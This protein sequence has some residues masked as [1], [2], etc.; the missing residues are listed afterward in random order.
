MQSWWLVHLWVGSQAFQVVLGVWSYSRERRVIESQFGSLK[1]AGIAAV[2]PVITL[3]LFVRVFVV[4]G[5]SN[6]AQLAG[7]N[8]FS[9]WSLWAGWWPLLFFGNPI[10]FVV[11]LIAS[12][13]SP[14]E[15]PSLLARW[16]G[17]MTAACACHAAF[18]Y[19][20]DA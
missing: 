8:G 10:S 13:C 2:V 1:A 14:Y 3:M 5:S 15:W 17:I 12:I 9:L 16:C 19:F 11:A 18:K 4:G 7:D 6:V 20:P